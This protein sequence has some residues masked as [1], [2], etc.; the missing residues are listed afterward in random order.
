[1]SVDD[2]IQDSSSRRLAGL[3]QPEIR[4][5]RREVWSPDTWD[6]SRLA[7][8]CHLA[9]RCPRDQRNARIKQPGC[10]DFSVLYRPQHAKTA[11]MGIN[12]RGAYRRPS[13]QTQL[14]CSS[15]R[16][17]L[18]NRRAHRPYSSADPPILFGY[19]LTQSNL[20][21]IR[22]APAGEVPLLPLVT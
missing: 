7:R 3:G 16:Q 9:R 12:N 15:Y 2:M 18:A 8:D 13:S 4:V 19:Q 11:G 17:A 20:A 1:M 22:I 21:P 10:K 14:F 6:E 5:H